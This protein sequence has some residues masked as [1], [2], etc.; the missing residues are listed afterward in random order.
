LIVGHIPIIFRLTIDVGFDYLP[1][2]ISI[3]WPVGGTVTIDVAS[4][5]RLFG[6]LGTVSIVYDHCGCRCV[7]TFFTVRHG[8]NGK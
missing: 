5:V 3:L 4:A 6:A 7:V 2:L 8:I 1:F